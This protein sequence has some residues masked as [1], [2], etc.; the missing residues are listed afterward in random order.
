[1]EIACSSEVRKVSH[2]ILN[3]LNISGIWDGIDT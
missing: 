3:D 2:S 1:M